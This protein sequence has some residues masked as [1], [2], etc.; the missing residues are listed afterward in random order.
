MLLTT[1]RCV[2]MTRESSRLTA[3]LMCSDRCLFQEWNSRRQWTASGRIVATET[4]CERWHSA[5][6]SAVCQDKRMASTFPTACPMVFVNEVCSQRRCCTLVNYTTAV[7][8]FP[9]PSTSLFPVGAH[10]HRCQRARY[11]AQQWPSP[12]PTRPP[13]SPPA[14]PSSFA[15]LIHHCLYLRLRNPQQHI[16]RRTS[17]SFG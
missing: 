3:I 4:L 13:T 5:D 16:L 15:H 7:L 8:F 14:I 6:G 11:F 10:A 2:P 17:T 1:C 9:S 12:T